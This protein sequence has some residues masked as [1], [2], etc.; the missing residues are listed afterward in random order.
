MRLSNCSVAATKKFLQRSPGPFVFLD[1]LIFDKRHR[2]SFLFDDFE[3]I[4]EFKSRDDPGVFFQ[5]IE[6]WLQRGYWLA[7][8]FEYEFGY[9]LEP[10][11]D[12]LRPKRNKVL[13]WLGVSKSPKVYSRQK[14]IFSYSEQRQRPLIK[15]IKA[16]ISQTEYRKN[17]AKI[18]Q[19]LELGLTYQV[20]YT[21][22]LK[23][24]LIADFYDL[25]ARLC[26][27]QPTSYAAL[28]NTGL[29]QIISLS[30]E[31]FFDINK[32][33]ITVRPMKGTIKRGI[34]PEEDLIVRESLRNS[35]KAKSENIMIVDLLRNDLGKVSSK[36]LVNR[37]FEIERYRTLYQMTS[38]IEARLKKGV[39]LNSIFSAIFPSGSVTGAPKIRTM[40][41]I[42][43]LEKGSR[44]IYTGSIGYFSPEKKAC[45][46]VAIR[47]VE[48]IGKKGQMGIGGGI[49]YDSVDKDEYRE[50]LLKASFFIKKEEDFSLVETLLFKKGD[51]I[52][53]KEHI[54][55]LKKS[56]EF[57][58][59]P[60]DIKALSRQLKNLKLQKNK[61][62]KIRVSMDALGGFKVEIQ[63]F[64][65]WPH[66]I[67][68]KI[69][70]KKIDPRNSF[71]Y[72]KTNQRDL[73]DEEIKTAQKE[74][75]SEVIFFN[76][77]QELTEGS[78]TN[79]FI[80]EGPMLY[81]PFKESG[82]LPGILRQDLLKKGK[83][84][85]K[86]LIHKDLTKA[87]KIYVGNSVRGL[88][89]AQI[90]RGKHR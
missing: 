77:N 48:L 29:K 67:K 19:Y 47:T 34:T 74:G 50:A 87:D 90:V 46:N 89:E 16:D 55:R 39:S 72:H 11:L 7:G 32:Y 45:F 30:P 10:A 18:K 64:E 68:V 88:V 26:F 62:L 31:L 71:L 69:S 65:P 79:I 76:L 85:E 22:K 54:A 21:F 51:F 14:G 6:A 15:N 35:L 4:I 13:A 43:E 1:T 25:Y 63:D 41:I 58:S 36:V 23:F 82:L 33:R 66:K 60:F 61:I 9:C 84:K 86:K 70:S 42:K 49:V 57:F 8:F 78:F 52:Y 20:N 73:Y 3:D 12:N 24:D 83:A 38:T 75:F 37:L 44:G 40:K 28:I 56:A 17:I 27:S 53:L 5:K 2:H 80:A 59:I 81:T